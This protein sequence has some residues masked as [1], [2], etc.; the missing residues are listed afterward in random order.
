MHWLSDHVE[1][2]R[3]AARA[4]AALREARQSAGEVPTPEEADARRAL[5]EAVD[6]TIAALGQRPELI[7]CFVAHEGLLVAG[8]GDRAMLEAAAAVSATLLDAAPSGADPLGLGEVAQLVVI[9]AARKLVLV[10]VGGLVLGLV[11]GATERL[12]RALA[13]ERSDRR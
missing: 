13:D 11:A 7:G 12:G 8:H 4:H 9:G 5:R 3:E 2:I 10:D 1:T 6:A